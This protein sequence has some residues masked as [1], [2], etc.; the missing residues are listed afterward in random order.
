MLE[1]VK[2][3]EWQKILS[4]SLTDSFG[5]NIEFGI[6][7]LIIMG[8]VFLSY[9]YKTIPKKSSLFS[10]EV[11]L[12]INLGGIGNI[13]IKQNKE[14]AQIAHKAWSEFITRKAGLEFDPEHDLIVEIYNSWYQLFERIRSLIKDIPADKINNKDTQ[15]LVTVLVD[16]LN[17]GLRPHLT[18]WQAKFRKW[19]EAELKKTINDDK[20]PQEIQK[21]YP[22]YNELVRD[23]MLINQQVIS[24]TNE[25]KKIGR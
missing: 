21:T 14:V 1:I 13:K 22:H 18:K 5:L 11:E 23:L 16:S 3:M 7:L 25:I 8:I 17:K 15:I 10:S 4:I 12:S 6:I 20:T 2:D 19:Y 24:Y 9:L